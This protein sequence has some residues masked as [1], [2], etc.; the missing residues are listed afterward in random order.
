MLDKLAEDIGS[1]VI[2]VPLPPSVILAFGCRPGT[3][4]RMIVSDGKI[5][6][7]PDQDPIVIGTNTPTVTNIAEACK[8][9]WKSQR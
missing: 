1:G 5:R 6:V 3:A 9:W 7:M 8:Q 4:I 2:V